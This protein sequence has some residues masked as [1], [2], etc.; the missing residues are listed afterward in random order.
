MITILYVDDDPAL[1]DL[2][3]RFLEKT[4]EFRVITGTSAREGLELV[5][6]H[7]VQAIVSDYQMPV[8]NGMDFLREVR[9][10]SPIPFIMFTGRGSEMIAM[11][12]TNSG[13]DY[14][15]Q[16]GADPRALFAEL[17]LKLR[18]AISDHRSE[19]EEQRT[20]K[21][22]RTLIDKTYDA[23]IIHSPDGHIMDV[24]EKMLTMFRLTREEALKM[25]IA[26]LSGPDAPSHLWPGII[27]RVLAGEDQFLVWEARHP[28]DGS[29][30]EIEKFITRINFGE[31]LYLLCNIRDISSTKRRKEADAAIRC[32]INHLPEGV[33]C[34]DE[35]GKIIFV[36][37]T[38]MERLSLPE[39]GLPGSHLSE[40]DPSFDS[41]TW[42]RFCHSLQEGP[43]S[44][45]TRHRS[46]EGIWIPVE[47][48]SRLCQENNRRYICIRL[49]E[50]PGSS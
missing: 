27:G 20:K 14:Y 17:T 4:S 42:T 45:Q 9:K 22:I 28:D 37:S 26:D 48:T 41:D 32:A 29:L 13:A 36:N 19:T 44:L 30:F 49:K 15:I 18:L 33:V 47:M 39:Y 21:T 6:K 11:E 40:I 7:P 12:A 35:D 3:K 2:A 34:T 16:K 25:S 24:N 46:R 50:L 8:M 1:L 31:H 23:V 43:V 5:Q 10:T 38:W